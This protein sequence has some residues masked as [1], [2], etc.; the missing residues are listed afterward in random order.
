MFIFGNM[1]P[2]SHGFAAMPVPKL[3]QFRLPSLIGYGWILT[4]MYRWCHMNFAPTHPNLISNGRR[5]CL[6]LWPAWLRN[7]RLSG[8]MVPN[9][10]TCENGLSNFS[11][12]LRVVAIKSLEL[13]HFASPNL[14]ICFNF[15]RYD[16]ERFFLHS[17]V[18]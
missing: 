2:E 5:N 13:T 17:P 11:T 7:Q 9:I 10:N 16:K 12:N 18:V 14:S 4:C 8:N 15:D 6:S 1:F 3:E